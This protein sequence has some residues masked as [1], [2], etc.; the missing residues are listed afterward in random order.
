M[1]LEF[2]QIMPDSCRPCRNIVFNEK[3]VSFR[4]CLGCVGRADRA[5]CPEARSEH[6]PFSCERAGAPPRFRHGGVRRGGMEITC[7]VDDESPEFVRTFSDW[8]ER[9]CGVSAKRPCAHCAVCARVEWRH[10]RD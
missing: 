1:N 3:G 6:G 4:A 10:H 7:D 9:E 5:R 2:M 8:L